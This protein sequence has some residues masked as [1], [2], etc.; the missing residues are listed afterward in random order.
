[1][2]RTLR[3]PSTSGRV[4]EHTNPAVNARIHLEMLHRLEDIGR[5]PAKIR[6]RLEELER[7]WDIERVL[8]ANAAAASLLGLSLGAFVHKRW[9]LFP[10]VVAGF[11][12][13]HA[14][15]GWCPPLP[16]FRKLGVR[17]AWEIE[18]ERRILEARRT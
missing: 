17:T 16:L 1:M 12:F 11:L 14:V 7:E 10:A 4:P 13:Q 6:A 18:E 5:D 15:Q 8:E 3:I 9:Y 2:A